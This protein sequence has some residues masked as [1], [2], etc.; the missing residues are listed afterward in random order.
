MTEAERLKVRTRQFAIDVIRLV[1]RFPRTI[2]AEVVGK[3]LLD[4]GTS[5]GA[6]YR[7]ACRSRS[8]AE[9]IS[10]ISIVCEES[11]ECEFWLDLAL[12]AEIVVH[13]EAKRLLRESA[14]LTAIATASRNTAKENLARRRSLKRPVSNGG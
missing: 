13:V 3:Q 11:D 7:A 12:A 2:D 8:A 6:N 10:K 5:V 9:F 4:A 1:R 14:E